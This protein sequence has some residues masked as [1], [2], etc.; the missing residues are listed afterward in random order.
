MSALEAGLTNQQV[1]T[2]TSDLSPLHLAPMVVLSTPD[3]IRLMEE[4]CT[5]AVQPLIEENDQ[6][7]V[8]IH[9]SVS[10]ESAAREGENVEVT[11]ELLEVDRRRLTFRVEVRVGERI[12]GQGT[13]QR[14]IV[15]RS[16][17]V[18]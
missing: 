1:V 7:T 2:V 11:C 14:H 16:R 8:G 17:F 13:H 12:I 5:A 3:M 6:T 4:T 15:D 18:G 10:H 9:V